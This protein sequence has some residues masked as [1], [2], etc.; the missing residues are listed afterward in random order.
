M[1]A[2]ACLFAAHMGRADQPQD[3][4]AKT[5][6]ENEDPLTGVNKSLRDHAFVVETGDEDASESLN[7]VSGKIDL[8][9]ASP[10]NSYKAQHEGRQGAMSDGDFHD[11]SSSG[12]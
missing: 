9:F 7:R 12:Y 4:P 5:V 10:Q 6:V 1:I 3:D 2:L 11:R 8:G